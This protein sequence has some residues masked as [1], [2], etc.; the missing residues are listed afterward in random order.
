MNNQ[1][2]SQMIRTYMKKD[3]QGVRPTSLISEAVK[4]L[5]SSK[6]SN[7]IVVDHNQPI[8]VLTEKDISR[9]KRSKRDFT[10]I[11]IKDVMSSRK[12][13][14]H[15]SSH[16][17][18]AGKAMEELG[19]SVIPIVEKG[20]MAGVFTIKNLMNVYHKGISLDIL[21]DMKYVKKDLTKITE[22]LISFVGKLN[23]NKTLSN[24]E[25]CDLLA[26]QDSLAGYN[27][28]AIKGA[29]KL[30]DM[31][32]TILAR[33]LGIRFGYN[34]NDREGLADYLITNKNLKNIPKY[35]NDY[36]AY[37]RIFAKEM[38]SLTKDDFNV[39]LQS[40]LSQ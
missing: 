36:I 28:F 11:R 17:G 37:T 23:K 10:T 34:K 25:V 20:S 14:F 35:K 31:T 1:M 38:G 8:G 40:V 32:Y 19:L 24:N 21:K 29:E 5:V 6:A 18:L 13:A 3:F 7:V 2:K 22:S 33:H 26:F 15:P 27:K 12:V 9:I 16:I 30:L 39:D 4:K